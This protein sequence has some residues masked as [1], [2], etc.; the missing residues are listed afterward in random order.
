METKTNAKISKFRRLYQ[1][2]EKNLDKWADIEKFRAG[3][4]E[5][6]Y[7]L[8]KIDD[9]EETAGKDLSSLQL[10]LE[11]CRNNIITKLIPVTNLLTL[12]A[13]DTKKKGLRKKLD[14]SR[15]N[16]EDLKHKALINHVDDVSVY[17]EKKFKKQEENDQDNKLVSYGLSMGLIEKLREDR[18]E[19]IMLK[20]NLEEENLLVEKAGKEIAVLVNANEDL[21]I[22][23][24]HLFMTVFEFSDPN[25]FTSYKNALNPPAPER[26]TLQR[27]VSRVTNTKGA[28]KKP[29]AKKIVQKKPATNTRTKTPVKQA[30]K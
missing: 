1:V 20:Q 16:L 12:Y 26:K 6:V 5:F 9:L 19:L 14:K 25:F 23:R 22:K 28:E 10:K 3:Y 24:F 11:A 7:N 18:D 17:L 21:I 15:K 29:V 8:K 27:P 30:T 4:D 13:L 2:M